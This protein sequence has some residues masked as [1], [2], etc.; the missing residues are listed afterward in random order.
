MCYDMVIMKVERNNW[1]NLRP[2]ELV[3]FLSSVTHLLEDDL[4]NGH[5]PPETTHIFKTREGG[6]G[7]IQV[8]SWKDEPE[9]AYIR[10]KMVKQLDGQK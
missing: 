10:Y 3:Q 7:I 9:G 1:Q 5:S 4:G 8:M 2:E 6:M